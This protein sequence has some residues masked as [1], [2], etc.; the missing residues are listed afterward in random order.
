M[1]NYLFFGPSHRHIALLDLQALHRTGAHC[2]RQRVA[3]LRLLGTEKTAEEKRESM[4][5]TWENHRKTTG[6]PQ[7][8]QKENHRKTIGTW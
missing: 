2:L 8:N 6:K 1:G 5:K 7:E 4:G 3:V